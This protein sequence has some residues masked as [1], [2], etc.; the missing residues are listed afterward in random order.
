MAVAAYASLIS[1][2]H[3]LDNVQHS[4]P[5]HQLYLYTKRTQSLQDKVKILLG[6]LELHSQRISQE[7]EDVARQIVVVVDEAEHIID[8]HVVN[9]LREGSQ[10]K[11]RYMAARSS[12][13]QDIS[14]IIKEIDSI[15]RKLM[16]VKE[17][18]VD[19][20]EQPVVPVGSTTLPSSDKNT[21]VGFDERLL[22]VVDELTRDEPNLQILPIVGM[23]GIGTVIREE[24]GL[25]LDKADKEVL[26]HAAKVVLT[27]DST[28][29][30][31]DGSIQEAVN[32]RV[33]QIRNLIACAP[34]SLSY[35]Y[36]TTFATPI[37]RVGAQTETELKEKKLGVEDTLNATKAAVEEGIVVGG[38]CT[39]LR[40]ASKV[41]AIKETLENDEEKVGADIV[42][43]AM[44]YPLK[45]IAKNAGVN[46]SVVSEKSK[47][48]L[49]IKQVARLGRTSYHVPGL[50]EA[51]VNNIVSEERG[52]TPPDGQ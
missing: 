1:L 6:Y 52:T 26:G 17:E 14:N 7:M 5:R 41:D 28:A 12:F 23:G 22:Q 42:K 10:D 48:G 45:L 18:W 4:A 32:K 9:Q 35:I 25:T 30:V 20:Q 37:D 47:H 15:T 21:M 43:R 19:V 29:I 38:G 36:V 49:E 24:I 13:G 27:K 16:M 11:R 46:G 50:I 31:G 40:L 34:L 2:T 33:A 51:H 8:F 44:S 39:L 3:V